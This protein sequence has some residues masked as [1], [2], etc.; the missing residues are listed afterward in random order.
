MAEE[1][2]ILWFS[3]HPQ[4]SQLSENSEH[5]PHPKSSQHTHD[6]R[7]Y[8]PHNQHMDNRA[9]PW[10]SSLTDISRRIH[11]SLS[12]CFNS[13]TLASALDCFTSTVASTATASRSTILAENMPVHLIDF[14]EHPT[15]TV[16]SEV[17]DFVNLDTL[18]TAS[19]LMLGGESSGL[20]RAA[21]RAPYPPGSAKHS[22]TVYQP[23][24]RI[25][26]PSPSRSAPICCAC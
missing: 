1:V 18:S 8:I 3:T 16:D 24:K 5:S 25:Q 13:S 22:T 20:H 23:R 21:L 9:N 14:H 19:H 10:H 2:D 6:H 11:N 7:E 17:M 4:H 15:W 26:N 12:S